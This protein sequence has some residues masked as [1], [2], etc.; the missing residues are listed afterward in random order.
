MPPRELEVRRLLDRYL[1]EIVEAYELCPWAKAARVGGDL[2]VTIMFGT[3]DDDAF[4]AAGQRLLAG[5]ARVAMVIAPELAADRERLRALRDRV[6]LRIP[7]A[8]I[9]EFYPDAPLELASPARLVPFLRRSPDPM[10]QLVPLALLASVRGTPPTADRAEQLKMLGGSAT[11]MRGD[12]A[13][14]IAAD[15]YARVAP[16]HAEIE[17][18][19]DD[20][21]RDRAASYAR[22]GISTCR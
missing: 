21:A 16:V 2:A 1:V 14:R 6:A 9:A 17:A 10:L 3:P 4:V 7:D 19:L 8:G 22:V 15:N 11:P 13:D 20:I 18:R 5:G 12:V